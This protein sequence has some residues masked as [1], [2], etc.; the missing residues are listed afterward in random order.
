MASFQPSASTFRK[1]KSAM[2]LLSGTFNA[3]AVISALY[4]ISGNPIVLMRR[5]GL[6]AKSAGALRRFKIRACRVSSKLA[7]SPRNAAT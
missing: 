2:I 5:Y 1:S 3:P 7:V 6:A 4:R